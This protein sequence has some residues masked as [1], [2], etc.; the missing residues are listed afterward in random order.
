MKSHIYRIAKNKLS[1]LIFLIM[2]FIPC[3]DIVL[4]LLTNTNYDPT[5]AFFLSGASRGHAAQMILLWFL[6]LYL[7]LLC[8]DDPIQDYKTGFYQVL[9]SK[10]GRKK[11]CTEKIM[12]SFLI[13]FSTMCVSLFINFIM[14]H[15][16]FFNGTFKNDLEQIKFPD[17]LLYTFSM[18]HPYY[19]ILLFSIVCCMLAGLIGALG[20]GVS[21]LFRD[22]K[23]AYPACFFIWFLLVLK[24]KS[25]V[26]LFQPFTEYGLDVLLPILITSVSIFFILIF[27]IIIY[28]VKYNEN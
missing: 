8:A 22:K 6:P 1:L 27:I 11:Y 19:A 17:N 7:L 18:S 14:V 25:L 3:I 2:I 24:K 15:I 16:L 9:V 23:Y 4:L 28:Q 20:A 26:Y 13:S 12:T 21:L 10:V 5:F